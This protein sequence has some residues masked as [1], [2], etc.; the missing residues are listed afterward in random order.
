MPLRKMQ[1]PRFACWAALAA[2]GFF[3]T[4]CGDPCGTPEDRLVPISELACEMTNG[5]GV[6]ES[7]PFP[8]I[9][10]EQCYW[11]EFRGCSTYEIVHPLGRVPSLVLGYTSF[12]QDGSFSTI[13]SGNSFVVEEANDSTVTVR[14]SQNQ[15]FYL[16]LVLE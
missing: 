11:L 14:N 16:R 6:W 12:D 4:A 13:G 5:E 3:T 1:M 7:H 8:P 15:L 2:V 9:A 10:D